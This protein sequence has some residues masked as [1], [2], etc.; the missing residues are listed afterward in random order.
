MTARPVELF[1]DPACPYAWMTSRWLHHAAEVRDIAPTFS[2]MSLGVLN[3]DRDLDPAYRSVTDE[4]WGAARLAIAILEREG[5]QALSDWYTAWGEHYHVGRNRE[6]RRVAAVHALEVA[7]LP[8]DLIDAYEDVPGDGIDASLR[9]S[10]QRAIDMVG[11]DVGTPVISF[12]EGT[13]Y[14]GPVISPAPRGEDAGRLLDGMAALA[15][16]DGFY[17]IKRTRTGDS[18]DFR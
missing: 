3:E 10:H 14:F 13:A 11:D 9:A 4:S 16:I 6:D 18:I 15:S 2:I 8:A 17:E 12:G 5:Q 7:G 1:I